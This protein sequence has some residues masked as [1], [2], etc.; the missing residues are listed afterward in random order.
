M[1]CLQGQARFPKFHSQVSRSYASRG[2]Y[3]TGPTSRPPPNRVSG[4]GH[5]RPFATLSPTRITSPVLPTPFS[6]SNVSPL[7]VTIRNRSAGEQ[8]RTIERRSSNNGGKQMVAHAFKGIVGQK[9]QDRKVTNC[10][11][12]CL[13]RVAGDV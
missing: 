7:T 4:F 3:K 1:R 2:G 9:Q 8:E 11:Y 5:S 13:R 6:S 10:C 12:C